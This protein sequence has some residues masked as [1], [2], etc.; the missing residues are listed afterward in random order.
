MFSRI[1]GSGMP[2]AILMLAYASYLLSTQISLEPSLGLLP[3]PHAQRLASCCVTW[4][5]GPL[6]CYERSV[7][8]NL[9]MLGRTCRCRMHMSQFGLGSSKIRRFTINELVLYWSVVLPLQLL[10][11]LLQNPMAQPLLFTG[12]AGVDRRE[13]VRRE[14]SSSALISQ[15]LEETVQ[16]VTAV[17]VSIGPK[18]FFF[19]TNLYI[20]VF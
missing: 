18:L 8:W 12:A 5:R 1:S 16:L 11:N 15:C 3:K 4:R 10:E 14:I 17:V 20:I 7:T 9:S 13:L 19:P 2:H 6:G